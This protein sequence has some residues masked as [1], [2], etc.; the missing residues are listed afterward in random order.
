MTITNLLV[1]LPMM[2]LCL[3]V[4]VATAFSAVRH[5]ARRS[6]RSGPGTWLPAGIVPLMIAMVIMMFGNFLQIVLWGALFV[7][8]GEFSSFYEAV[9]HSAV[10]YA[11]LGYGDVVMSAPWK[12]LGPLEALNGVL[13]LGMTGAAL[14]AMVQQI[15][16][17][18]R[19]SFAAGD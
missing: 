4:Q 19:Q 14:M 17:D 2:L 7:F 6:G 15:I 18:Q 13:M 10:N 5:Y 11:S 16:K 9:Y 12:M 8:L 1:G 3:M